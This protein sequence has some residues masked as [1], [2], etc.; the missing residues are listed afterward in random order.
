MHTKK[1]NKPTNK[2]ILIYYI[3]RL[4]PVCD[5]KKIDKSTKQLIDNNVYIHQ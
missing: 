3:S 5:E 1:T 4:V 2:Y